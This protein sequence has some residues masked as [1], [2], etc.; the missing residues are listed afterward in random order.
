MKQH[1]HPVGVGFV[2]I[3]AVVLVISVCVLAGYYW[4]S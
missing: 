2:A 1:W 3:V 4:A